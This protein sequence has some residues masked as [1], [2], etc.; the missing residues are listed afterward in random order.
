[1][2][3]IQFSNVSNFL[4]YRDYDL[5][6]NQSMHVVSKNNLNEQNIFIIQPYI[7]WGPKKAVI[8]P[9][10]QLQEAE[11]LV[12]TLPNWNIEHS[13]KVSVENMDKKLLFGSG[14]LE[15]IKEMIG[16]V[17]SRGKNCEF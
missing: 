9:E 15:E 14:K 11:S 8:K 17:M 1:M 16:Q 7:K 5:I 10:L 3:F 6:A 4:C 13:I 2:I 12:R